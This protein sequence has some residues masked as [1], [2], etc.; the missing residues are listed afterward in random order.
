MSTVTKQDEGNTKDLSSGQAYTAGGQGGA[1]VGTNAKPQQQSFTNLRQF[2]NANQQAGK[3]IASTVDKNIS[4]QLGVQ[5]S[6]TEQQLGQAQDVTKQGQGVLGQGQNLLGQ[7]ATPQGN[8]ISAGPTA[9][10][11]GYATDYT[12]AQ[13]NQNQNILNIAGD[14]NK[15][16]EF[17]G[18]R[19]GETLNQA[20]NKANFVQQQAQQQAQQ[21]QQNQQQK[22]QQLQT[23]TGR[24]GLLK[25]LVGG[26]KYGSGTTALDQAFLQKQ[27][28]GALDALKQKVQGYSDFS[29]EAQSKLGN[30]AEQNRAIQTGGQA[31]SSGI[32]SGLTSTQEAMRQGLTGLQGDI[33]KARQEQTDW[34]KSQYAK[35]TPGA[36]EAPQ[37][38][39]QN[40]ANMMGLKGG[41]RLYNLNQ[42]DLSKFADLSGL[43]GASSMQDV[44]IDKDVAYANA[45]KALSGADT[46]LVNKA[47]DLSTANV[48]SNLADK[49]KEAKEKFINYAR[50]NEI[51]GRQEDAAA[52]ANLADYLSNSE[53]WGFMQGGGRTDVDWK[54]TRALDLL[55][56]NVAQAANEQGYNTVANVEGAANTAD[57]VFANTRQQD[58]ESQLARGTHGGG[59]K[60]AVPELTRLITELNANPEYTGKYS[61]AN[62]YGG[63]DNLLRPEP[64]YNTN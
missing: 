37:A 33:N 25:Q 53:N 48:T 38:I 49:I 5:K 27:S 10:A 51:V 32:Q 6:G 7:I 64:E 36:G 12:T 23:E 3:N 52:Q 45:L 43:A 15:L 42:L 31:L 4:N 60:Y 50:G 16:N 26:N 28:G 46:A 61:A 24:S 56:S 17:T 59:S 44:A 13:R 2:L 35:L 29:K 18:F 19:T 8:Y 14:T 9:N 34:A 47:S 55:R 63:F 11:Q 54:R 39:S 41:E 30:L 57:Q 22:A 40:F 21:L 20:A 58:I 62:N 1:F